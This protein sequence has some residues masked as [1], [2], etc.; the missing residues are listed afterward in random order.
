MLLKIE[1]TKYTR[2]ARIVVNY[3]NFIFHI[4]V[5]T[6]SMQKSL[7]FVFQFIKNR[8]R[9]FGYTDSVAIPSKLVFLN[10]E[11]NFTEEQPAYILFDINFFKLIWSC[12]HRIWYYNFWFRKCVKLIWLCI[13]DL[14]ITFDSPQVK[15]N[16][17]FS[18]KN[19]VYYSPH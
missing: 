11:K 17:I 19:F 2:T 13:S 3:L 7:N 12:K 6:K 18:T 15:W 10:N 9:Q 8:K 4:E 16:S 14:R 1:W 5:K